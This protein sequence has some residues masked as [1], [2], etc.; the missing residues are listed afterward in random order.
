MILKYISIPELNFSSSWKT[1]WAKV[2]QLSKFDKYM[3][4]VWLLGP[5]IFLIERSPADIWLTLIGFI[6]LIRC[7]IKVEWS[8]IHQTWFKLA[9]VLWIIG[10]F[11]GLTGP[12]PYFSFT[13]GFAWI[14]FP[15]FAM[16][17]Q[18]WLAKDRD[19]R[20]IM[21]VSM[22]VGMLIMSGILI[23]ETIIEPKLRL[24]WPYDDLVPG[25]YVTKFSLPLFCI[26]IAIAV[27][28][29][30]SAGIFSGIIGMLSIIVSVL[31]GERSNFV[32]R[33][34]GGMFAGLI[35]KP[36]ALLYLFLLIIEIIAVLIIA[37]L[38]PDLGNRFGKEFVENI[39]GPWNTEMTIKTFNKKTEKLEDKKTSNAYWGAWRSGIQ[40]ALITPIKG[41]GPS[42]T[43][44]TCQNLKK[45]DFEWLPGKNYC[46]NHPHNFYVQ[47]FAETGIFGF[48]IGTLMFGSIILT[49]YKA[50]KIDPNC[51]MHAT[52]FVVPFALFFPIQQFGSFY[53]QWGNLFIWFAIAFAIAQ[54]QGWRKTSSSS[55][56]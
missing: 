51:P 45:E 1:G 15:L 47:L 23:S 32:V 3:T 49:C 7:S 42:G 18:V 2:N 54:Y 20:I 40:Q 36:K 48:I 4:I 26:L 46:G 8:W 25:A 16:A 34:C 31:T 43:R 12:D 11:S 52:A 50:R 13:Q 53:G 22:L 56:K 24:T 28:R 55:E 17:T 21:L 27:S 41:I 9:L 39:P 29:K 33:A 44:N 19:I 5:F 10:L 35:W 14:R 6:F 38:R 37:W 30:T